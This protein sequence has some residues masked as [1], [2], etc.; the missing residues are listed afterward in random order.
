MKTDTAADFNACPSRACTRHSRDR[1]TGPGLERA[2]IMNVA[3]L[4]VHAIATVSAH[5]HDEVSDHAEWAPSEVL[6]SSLR[7]ARAEL[8]DVRVKMASCGQCDHVQA[9]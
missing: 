3:T 1:Q 6:S 5:G 7:S 4:P 9:T 2:Q 8:H